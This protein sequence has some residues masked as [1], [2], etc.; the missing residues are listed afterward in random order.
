MLLVVFGAFAAYG[1][2]LI[3]VPV[4][5]P[6][7]CPPRTYPVAEFSFYERTVFFKV[8]PLDFLAAKHAFSFQNLHLNL[9][10]TPLSI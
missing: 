8:M 6:P 9:K 7:L 4:G 5:A 2:C 10:L 1:A 3:V